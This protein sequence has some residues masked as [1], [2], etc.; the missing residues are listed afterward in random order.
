MSE[1]NWLSLLR[2][3]ERHPSAKVGTDSALRDGATP[4]EIAALELRLGLELPPSYRQFLSVTNGW[5]VPRGSTGRFWQTSEVDWFR[6]R[7]GDWIEAYNTTLPG[8]RP[9]PR[10]TDAEYFVYGESQDPVWFRPEYLSS[11]LEISDEGDSAIYLLNPEIVTPDGEWEAWFFA[12]WLPG[13]V[14]YPSFW[15]LMLAG[16]DGL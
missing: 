9:A 2:L 6:E 16:Y 13:A 1:E 5:R 4:D 3:W 10:A 8:L 14:R 7:H 15:A 11:A 12:N